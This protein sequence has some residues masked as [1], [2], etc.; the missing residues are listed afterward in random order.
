MN[1]A[2]LSDELVDSAQKTNLELANKHLDQ[3]LISSIAKKFYNLE[4]L[5]NLQSD[6]E[7]KNRYPL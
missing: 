1:K 6:R 7:G 5:D 4:Y 3:K 2:L